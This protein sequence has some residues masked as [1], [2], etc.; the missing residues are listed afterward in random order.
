MTDRTRE[1]ETENQRTDKA[2]RPPRPSTEPK[3]SEWSTRTD[4]TRTDPGT[5]EP[6]RAK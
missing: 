5:G 3:G 2:G 1:S 6:N 4:K